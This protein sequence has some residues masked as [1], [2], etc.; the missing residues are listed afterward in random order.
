MATRSEIL[1]LK[2]DLQ[3][4][5]AVR[6]DARFRKSVDTT[7]KKSGKSFTGLT[8]NVKALGVGL[9]ALAGTAV[10]LGFAFDRFAKRAEQVG[11]ITRAFGTLSTRVGETR[12]AMLSSMREASDGL[13]RDFDLMQQANN[14][15]LLGLPVTA[16][17][18]GVLT[19]AAVR[20]GAAMGRGPVDSVSSLIEG[21]GRQSRQL[22]DNLSII[23]DVSAAHKS[24]AAAIG[25]SVSE[26][27][28][29][30]RR[31]A[32]YIAGLKAAKTAVG[33]LGSAA[34]GLG[35]V[36]RTLT[37]T[38][39]NLADDMFRAATESAAFRDVL[40]DSGIFAAQFA[41]GVS[42]MN[43]KLN[44]FVPLAE[45]ARLAVMGLRMTPTGQQLFGFEQM[46]RDAEEATKF[47][48]RLIDLNDS[49]QK[50]KFA[51]SGGTPSLPAPTP[52]PSGGDQADPL[53]FG[54]DKIVDAQKELDAL[55][56]SFARL[57][58]LQAEGSITNEQYGAGLDI[59][60]D[61]ALE[62]ND[63][64]LEPLFLGLSRLGEEI[65]ELTDLQKAMAATTDLMAQGFSQAGGAMLFAALS[66]QKANQSFKQVL[67]QLGQSAAAQAIYETAIGIA[68]LTPWGEALYGEPAHHFAAA[69]TFGVA[70]GALA[71]ASRAGGR[72]GADGAT[73]VN[74]DSFIQPL[75]AAG[76]QGFVQEVH[77]FIEGQGFVTDIDEFGRVIRDAIVQ[78]QGRAGGP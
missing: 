1:A 75:P 66:G 30:D 7:A 56:E 34:Q 15:V 36:W 23:V 51:S 27:T 63:L 77:V 20:L 31:T 2:Y 44:E 41:L 22:L 59:I 17:E 19:D 18:M 69:K 76:G 29:A 25:V 64:G 12:D 9:T 3:T 61:K 8:G 33:D 32:F 24:Y 5:Q 73:G 38:T 50:L 45:A 42:L 35:G 28:D 37:T 46:A 11:N 52:A 21:L 4:G 49:M 70:A 65:V 40:A 16:E 67:D 47:Q 10:A 60:Q 62:L 74:Q 72:G 54:L 58:V 43:A 26:L 78:Q 55:G 39:Q 53:G 71:L 48:Q 13:V 6:E 14:A 68:A 57:K